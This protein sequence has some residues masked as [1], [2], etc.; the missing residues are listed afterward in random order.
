MST[1]FPN[2]LVVGRAKTGTTVISKAIQ[3]SIPGARYHLEPKEPAFFE[4]PALVDSPVPRVVKIIYEHWDKR[5]EQR[6]ALLKNEMPLKFGKIILIR[7]D[8]RDELISRLFYSSFAYYRKHGYRPAI[9]REWRKTIAA[10]EKHPES[11]L[12]RTL[13]NRWKN[14]TGINVIKSTRGIVEYA[15][16]LN[17]APDGVHI[18]A[19][20]D[21]ISGNVAGLE[22]YLELS[23]SNVRD[24]GAISRTSRSNASNNWKSLFTPADVEH[25]RRRLRRPM[26]L[27]GYDD[28]AL[29]DAPV[30]DPEHGTLYLDRLAAE[31]REKNAAERQAE[32]G[33]RRVLV[34]RR[35][36]T[37]TDAIYA[38]APLR[39][40]EEQG[41]VE[42]HTLDTDAL[43]SFRSRLG[44]KL[45][46]MDCVVIPRSLPTDWIAAI[47][48]RADDLPRVVYLFDD[49]FDSVARS[50]GIPE[51]YAHRIAHLAREEFP[52]LCRLSARVITTSRE[53][54]QR[55]AHLDPLLMHPPVYAAPVDLTH[56]DREDTLRIAYYGTGVH[57]RDLAMIGPALRAV[58]DRYAHVHITVTGREF[59]P[60]IEGLPR[61]ERLNQLSWPR[62][63]RFLEG[64]REHILLAPL[65]ETPFNTAKSCV[66]YV[67]ACIVGAAGIFSRSA[68]YEGIVEHER[69][70]ILV[71]N[72]TRHW[73]AAMDRLAQDHT[74]R[75]QIAQN[76][77]A[78]AGGLLS[79]DRAAFAWR[80]LLSPATAGR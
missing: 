38:L 42:L 21:F 22:A 77:Q 18:L 64:R 72:D 59:P 66:K 5:P 60:E 37:P 28:W 14:L 33:R 10:K 26:K 67:E 12:F 9:A 58:H 7:R 70:G 50:D 74:F 53:L 4:D 1:R 62:F 13:V 63:R 39:R 3:H 68:P 27:L 23:L 56:H 6:M 8:P 41:D 49:D 30:L 75:K 20:E 43:F 15:R 40:L 29:D 76:A 46:G 55:F 11:V 54:A 19:Y 17:Q 16:F 44:A 52:R 57:A 35:R 73:E 61:V 78:S 69:T 32:R 34:L 48:S 2:V 51:A 24:V 71:D 31:A 79:V 65:R 45:R 80:E 36:E 25:F 47:E